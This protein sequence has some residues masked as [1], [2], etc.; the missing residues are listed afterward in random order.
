MPDKAYI[1]S[2]ILKW[3]RET[4]K[5]SKEVAASKVKVDSATIQ[6]WEEGNDY[7]TIRQAQ[8]LAKLYRRPFALFFLPD[9]PKDFQPL[10]DFRSSDAK[11]LSSASVFII[12]EIQ[13]KHAWISEINQENNEPPVKFIG[14]FS[15][16]DEP[17]KVSDDILKTLKINPLNYTRD[18]P[19]LEWA[20]KAEEAGI[21]VSRTSFIHSRLKIDSEELKGFAIADPHAPFIFINSDDWGTAQ[22]FTLVHEIAHLWIA[23]S[24][25]S[26][27]IELV[28][29]HRGKLHPIEL[30]CNEVAAN[31]LIPKKFLSTLDQATFNSSKE[32]YSVSKKLGISAFAFLVRIYNLKLITAE[33]YR[34][35]KSEANKAYEI[36]LEQEEKKKLRQKEKEGGPN[37]YLLQINKN[38]K[39][40]TKTVLD[41]FNEGSIEPTYASSLLNVKVNKFPKLVEQLFK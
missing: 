3:A 34:H 13:Q 27:D 15:I 29:N 12:R 37:F 4:A 41:A 24:G 2:K 36:Y 5:M 23:K 10:Q 19:I 26:S 16:N 39:L 33:Q 35:L 28:E 32:I 14:R 21:F 31:V 25:I 38:S 30:F 8:E 6:E 11:P 17:Q 7:P 9:I 20:E 18:N 40:F 22:L 1:T